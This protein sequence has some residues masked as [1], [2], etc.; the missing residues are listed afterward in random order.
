MYLELRI[1]ACACMLAIASILDLKN[2]E[3]PDKVW[4]IFGG[5]GA[6]IMILELSDSSSP[7][8]QGGSIPSAFMIQYTLGIALMSAIGYATYRTGLFGGADPKALVAIAVILPVFDSAFMIHGFTAL[9]VL[10]NALIISMS[11]MLYNVVRNTI[12]VT[13]GIPIFEGISENR[14]K[15]ALA[16]AVGFYSNSS[17]KF[18]F[19]MEEHDEDGR[20]KFRFNPSSYDEFETDTRKRWVTQALP[21]ILYIGMGFAVMLFVG[22]LLA[23]LVRLMF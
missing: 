13:R 2:R 15:K 9:T 17:G 23:L 16:F 14:I 18:L 8:R 7:L 12:S 21:F 5:M 6:F 4:A 19:A 1:A 20:K 10:S 22:D 3:I 11:G